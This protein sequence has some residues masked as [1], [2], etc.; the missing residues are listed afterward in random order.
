MA[1]NFNELDDPT[2]LALL[3]AN[4]E[5]IRRLQEEIVSLNNILEL[6]S[7]KKVSNGLPQSSPRPDPPSAEGSTA[8]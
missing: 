6:R 8:S 7:L 3:A 5:A 2:L 4:R 1:R